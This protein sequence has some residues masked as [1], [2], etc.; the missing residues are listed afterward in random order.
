MVAAESNCQ[1]VMSSAEGWVEWNPPGGSGQ[2]GGCRGSRR[3]G[4][5]STSNQGNQEQNESTGMILASPIPSNT[6]PSKVLPVPGKPPHMWHKFQHCIPQNGAGF[7]HQESPTQ[8]KPCNEW[9]TPKPPDN[10]EKQWTRIRNGPNT[11]ANLTVWDIKRAEREAAAKRPAPTECSSTSLSRWTLQQLENRGHSQ[12][13]GPFGTNNKRPSKGSGIN[14]LDKPQRRSSLINPTQADKPPF[15]QNQGYQIVTPKFPPLQQSFVAKSSHRPGMITYVPLSNPTTSE[16]RWIPRPNKNYAGS[17]KSLPSVSTI[18]DTESTTGMTTG[19]QGGSDI[20]NTI[21]PNHNLEPQGNSW[22]KYN[23][24]DPKGQDNDNIFLEESF[25]ATF[26]NAWLRTTSEDIEVSF[27]DTNDSHDCDIDT[28]TG[29]LLPPM[30]YPKTMVDLSQVNPAWE[31]RRQNWTATL[32]LKNLESQEGSISG[33]RWDIRNVMAEKNESESAPKKI[34]WK[35]EKT[36]S[37]EELEPV[38]TYTPQVPCYLRPAVN[39]DMEEVA[40]IYNWEVM[41]GLQAIDSEPL[42][43]KDFEEIFETT[44]KLGMPFLVAL[45]GSARRPHLQK[46]NVVYYSPYR[47]PKTDE[48]NHSDGKK[49]GKVIGFAYLSVWAPGLAGGGSGASRATAKI[50]LFVH[51]DQRRKKIGFSL[52]DKLLSTISR[53][54]HLENAYDFVD[55][56]NCAMHKHSPEHERP[57]FRVYLNYNVKH[58]HVDDKATLKEDKSDDD[59]LEWVKEILEKK[60]NFVEKV[61]FDS[62]YR[63][64]KSRE[65]PVFWLDSV[66]FE[67]TCCTESAFPLGN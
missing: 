28:N 23:W 18:R 33:N 64:P 61:R 65:G 7:G 39:D 30:E 8:M 37:E 54:F 9:S 50:N 48:N 26:V 58:R 17:S 57:Y 45:S 35:E 43:V 15:G 27:T 67:H 56:A 63:S 6:I 14:L 41:N 25:I 2:R 31:W 34:E 20:R 5:A 42:P 38:N 55:P 49:R 36:E 53:T 44:R 10:S 66:L 3:G 1:E 19:T 47:Q 4:N 11:G 24:D 60:F 22:I 12:F 16:M 21:A 52:M 32:L 13:D 29:E 46:G 40:G 51:P 62:V 59:E